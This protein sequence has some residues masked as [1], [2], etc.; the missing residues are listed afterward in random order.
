MSKKSA[1]RHRSYA[2]TPLQKHELNPADLEVF[3]DT[4][5]TAE[6]AI[7]SEY[8]TNTPEHAKWKTANSY[9]KL[10]AR[11]MHEFLSTAETVILGLIS[12]ISANERKTVDMQPHIKQSFEAQVKK[13]SSDDS[14]RLDKC[15]E[16]LEKLVFDF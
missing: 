15:K 1:L 14:T 6:N 7:V 13:L 10:I 16:G 8:G 12:H 4:M 9:D 3:L 2:K 11:D 5:R